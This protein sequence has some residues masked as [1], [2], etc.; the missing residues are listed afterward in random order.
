M[1]RKRIDLNWTQIEAMCQLMCTAEEVASVFKCTRRALQNRCIK[2]NGMKWETFFEKHCAGG[3]VS[4]RRDLFTES[5]KGNV[6]A[7]I[8]LA[9]NYLGMKDNQELNVKLTKSAEELSDA[10]LNA[11][12]SR[13]RFGTIKAPPVQV[14]SN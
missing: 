3:K 6:A 9:K 11:I 13:S 12:A 4:I 14:S 5:K 2:D 8:F 7:S 1:T 10:E